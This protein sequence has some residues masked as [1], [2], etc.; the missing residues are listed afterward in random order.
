[1]GARARLLRGRTRPSRVLHLLQDSEGYAVLDGIRAAIA[2]NKLP[3]DTPS[4][5]AGYSGG[6]HATAWAAN[7]HSKYASDLNIIG[8]VH[9]GTPVDTRG[10]WHRPYVTWY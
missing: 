1:M 8:A 4:V 5:M 9:G 6:A 3:S 10:A 7:L 2:L